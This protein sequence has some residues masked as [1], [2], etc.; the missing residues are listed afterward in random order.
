MSIFSLLD[1]ESEVQVLDKTR[2]SASK[3]FAS[4]AVSEISSLTIKPELSGS[5]I[6]CFNSNSEDMFLDWVYSDTLID[7]GAQN[8]DV[9]FNE[10]GSDISTNLSAGTYTLSQFATELASKMQTA[11]TK[12]YSASVSNNKITITSSGVFKF[13]KSSAQEQGFFSL[14]TLS[15]T[16]VSSEV[17]YG[18]KIVT[19]EA[20]NGTITDEKKFYLKCY[21][22]S[23]D[24][25]F[26]NTRDLTAH[27]PDLVKWIQDGHSSYNNVIR[28]SQKLIMAWLDE[29]G[30]VNIYGDKFTKKDVIDIEEVKQ[31]SIFMSLRLIFQ[32][33]SN[34]ID[35]I[36]DRK[37]KDYALNEEAARQRVVLR[38]DSDKDGLA[39]NNEGMS[40]YS[41]SLY[42]R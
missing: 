16:H 9:I 36:F 41:G 32:G 26:C 6:D 13:I 10:G 3:S 22:E 19:V 11:G 35:D 1:F 15:S 5:A 23:G 39:D 33:M 20:S 37:S 4:K 28:R 18:S 38:I 21:S 7:I 27:E 24:Y 2:L 30:Y 12:T 14:K 25:L 34:A 31:W 17:E 40:I 8:D 29:K 42:R